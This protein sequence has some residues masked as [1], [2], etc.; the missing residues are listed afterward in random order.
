MVRSGHLVDGRVFTGHLESSH[1]NRLEDEVS[2]RDGKFRSRYLLQHGYEE[3][4][5]EI[6]AEKDASE[7][8]RYVFEVS[9][10][11]RG[12]FEHIN[13]K[14]SIENDDIYLAM[15]IVK[16]EEVVGHL[17]FYGEA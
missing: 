10:P 12:A 3:V 14:G 5:Y 11:K 6:F 17:N 13:V 8:E 7:A 1:G 9:V 4:D 15:T 2:F 16:L